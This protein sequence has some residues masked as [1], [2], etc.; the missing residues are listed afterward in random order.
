MGRGAGGA[1]GGAV[2]WGRRLAISCCAWGM[3]APWVSSS[4]RRSVGMAR[5]G[6]GLGPPSV[7]VIFF[8]TVSFFFSVR[9]AV[10]LD[11]RW[12]PRD[13]GS[14]GLEDC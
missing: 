11:D 2:A 14:E 6:D 5:R 12:V 8:R 10:S 9:G 4:G 7:R 1:A 3:A 13:S